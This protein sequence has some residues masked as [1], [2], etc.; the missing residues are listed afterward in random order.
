MT[1]SLLH[2]EKMHKLLS[3]WGETLQGWRYQLQC[4][5]SEAMCLLLG[6]MTLAPKAQFLRNS[7]TLSYSNLLWLTTH[8]ASNIHTYT[9]WVIYFYQSN[10][11]KITGEHVTTW[12]TVHS[13]VSVVPLVSGQSPTQKSPCK[14][15]AGGGRGRCPLCLPSTPQG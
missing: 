15:R 1:W 9:D 6:S 8:T 10:A 13:S 4:S 2:L 7:R 11:L 3:G 14:A 5:P 12:I